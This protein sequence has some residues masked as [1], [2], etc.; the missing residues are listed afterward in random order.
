MSRM[1]EPSSWNTP[2]VSPLAMQLVAS[3]VVERQGG[4]IERN[5]AL[6]QQCRARLASTVSVF[7]PRKSNFTRP[8]NSTYFMLNCVTGMSERGSR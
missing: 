6:G 7:R 1:P 4:K 2:T 8:A 3:L 5:A